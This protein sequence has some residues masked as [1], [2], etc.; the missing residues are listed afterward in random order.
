MRIKN[1]KQL[2]ESESINQYNIDDYDTNLDASYIIQ[3]FLE[4]I[5]V[6]FGILSK[7]YVQVMI[8]DF[9]SKLTIT[10]LTMYGEEQ[11]DAF[12]NI[13]IDDETYLPYLIDKHVPEKLYTKKYMK[14]LQDKKT[15]EFNI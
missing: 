8:D 15:K 2:T 4:E 7:K 1:F 12:H 13:V 11:E 10:E 6:L 5:E 9:K 14:T 3:L